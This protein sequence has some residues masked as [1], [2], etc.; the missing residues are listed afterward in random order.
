MMIKCSLHGVNNKHF[1]S[2]FNADLASAKVFQRPASIICFVF[3]TACSTG[4]KDRAPDDVPVDVMTVPDAVPRVES[5]NASNFRSYEIFGKRYFPL[6]DEKGF[7]QRGVASWYGQKFH[8]NKTANGETYDMFA[9]TAAH[10]T[11]PIPSYV[12]VTNLD[13]GHSVVVRVNDRGPFHGN[14]IIDLSYTAAAKLDILRKGT[15]RVEVV[16]VL[17]GE[18]LKI[19]E[20]PDGRKVVLPSETGKN[21]FL[22]VGAFSNQLN[23]LQLKQRLLQMDFVTVPARLKVSSQQGAQ[24]YKVQ[25]GPMTTIQQAG[26][27]GQQLAA[28][29]ITGSKMV[30]EEK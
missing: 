2:F 20:K 29:G 24:I 14:R 3:F 17:P 11:L 5:R 9:M 27:V 25:L 16:S 19:T 7:R 1:E 28:N 22:Q 13:N 12:R 23:A 10:K 6:K 26:I 21:L 8:G 18:S 4:V 30:H 15:G